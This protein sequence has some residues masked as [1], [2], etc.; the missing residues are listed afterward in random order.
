MGNKKHEMTSGKGNIIVCSYHIAD[1]DKPVQGSTYD[2][3]NNVFYLP[4]LTLYIE[5]REGRFA[6]FQDADIAVLKKKL[7]NII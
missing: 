7:Q 4:G 6:M 1:A 5:D 3:E 2:P